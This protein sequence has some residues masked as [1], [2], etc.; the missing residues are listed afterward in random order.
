M[1]I[2][3]RPNR[4]VVPLPSVELDS[5]D[6]WWIPRPETLAWRTWDEEIILYDERADET[7]HFDIATAAVFEALVAKPA[8]LRELV[9]M[10]AD[11]LQVRA[12]DELASMVCQIVRMLDEKHLLC[13]TST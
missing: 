3:G 9:R 10:L 1:G 6:R 2:Q 12:D 4:Q 7:H 13:V 5:A 11:R 8:S